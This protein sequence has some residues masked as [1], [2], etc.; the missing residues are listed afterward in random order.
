MPEES[1]NDS[2]KFYN[3]VIDKCAEALD[4][5]YGS[6]YDIL[7]D[8]DIQIITKEDINDNKQLHNLIKK[9]NFDGIDGYTG[10]YENGEILV[11][12][13]KLND[14]EPVDKLVITCLH[15]LTHVIQIKRGADFSPKGVKKILQ[16]YNTDK[17]EDEAY[18]NEIMAGKLIDRI[19]KSAEIRKKWKI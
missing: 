4:E 16:T 18:N 14:D 3:Y 11:I 2:S 15:E 1:R 13:R 5:K 10:Q 9:Y 7:K 8:V 19:N 17:N 6:K 12:I